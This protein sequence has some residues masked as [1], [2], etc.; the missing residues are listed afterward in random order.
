MPSQVDT[1]TLNLLQHSKVSSTKR[2]QVVEAHQSVLQMKGIAKRGKIHFKQICSHCHMAEGLGKPIGPD[3]AAITDRSPASMLIAILDPN[4]AVED[5][6]LSYQVKTQSDQTHFGM[7]ESE[8]AN[9]LT[10]CLPDGSRKILPRKQI[11]NL[12]SLG[13]SLMPDGLETALNPQQLADLLAY[14]STLGK[15]EPSPPNLHSQM[16]ARIHPQKDGTIEL[17][18]KKCRLSGDKISY[19]PKWDAL[20][21]WTSRED[22]AEWTIVLD[23]SGNYDVEWEWSV[24]PKH[25]GNSWQLLANGQKALTGKVQPTQSWEDFQKQNIGQVRLAAA[26]TKIVLKPEGPLRE[27]SALLDLRLIRFIPVKE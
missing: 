9:H 18:A 11:K 26:D 8:S 14:L 19:M 13:L 23:H 17:R 12:K 10:L 1:A 20:G 25:S 3:I 2:A 22:R 6:F 16:S 21:W 4:R 24:D 27:N 5:K 15:P 7:I